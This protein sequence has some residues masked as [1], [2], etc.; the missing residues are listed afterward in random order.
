MRLGMPQQCGLEERPQ[1]LP[2]T[3]TAPGSEW[4]PTRTPASASGPPGGAMGGEQGRNKASFLIIGTDWEFNLRASQQRTEED[5]TLPG[6][7]MI[8]WMAWTLG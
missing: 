5:C 6:L 8:S 4:E 3:T 2:G 1:P 7:I